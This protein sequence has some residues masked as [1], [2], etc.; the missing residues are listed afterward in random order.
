[1][2][3][4]E[5][6]KFKA[7][8]KDHVLEEIPAGDLKAFYLKRPGTRMGSSLILFTP[9]GIVI[10]GDM[11]PGRG[12]L[13]AFGY[14]LSWFASE[15]GWDYLCGK[16]LDKEWVPEYAVEY[17]RDAARDIRRGKHDDDA[18]GSELQ[19]AWDKRGG[20]VEEILDLRRD[21]RES[22][23]ADKEGILG[24]KK[25]ME[26]ARG[27]LKAATATVKKLRRDLAEKYDE[28]ASCT[29]G[30]NYG[31]ERFA[32]EIQELDTYACEDGVPGWGFPPRA[33]AVLTAI[34]Q[35]FSELYQA[36]VPAAAE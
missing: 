29:E 18:Y 17:C 22:D 33:A 6:E 14:G 12:A 1:M 27:E 35:K 20:L 7:D 24:L 11:T 19:K 13:S 21:L 31:V 5:V 25:M 23:P 3:K 36:G 30:W 15:L 16:F 34:Q 28:L 10:A 32:E 2:M 4:S 8:F 26:K 9:E